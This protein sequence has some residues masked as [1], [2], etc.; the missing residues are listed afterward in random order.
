MVWLA[1]VEDFAEVYSSTELTQNEKLCYLV[2]LCFKVGFLS[3]E[4]L[5]A[6]ESNQFKSIC[7]LVAQPIVCDHWIKTN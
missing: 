4:N 7:A 2:A 3:N 5:E 1:N 6:D